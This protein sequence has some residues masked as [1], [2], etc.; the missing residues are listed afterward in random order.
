MLPKSKPK[1]TREE[2]EALIRDIDA[3]VIL[4]GVRG[5]YSKTFGD[6][7]N[8]LN[9][10]DDAIFL[11]SVNGHFSFNANTDPS[12]LRPRVAKLKQGLWH[13]RLGTHNISKPKSQQYPAL[14]QAAPVTVVR[15]NS[16]E[17]TGW[18]GINIH[19]GG[20]TTTS[21][22][23]CQTIPPNQWLGFYELV[24]TEMNRAKVSR[25]PYL[26]IDKA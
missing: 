16:G 26:L 22:L 8:D 12:I 7:G 2:T 1:Q 23:G 15:H 17:D 19:R 24:R 6:P 25:I 10:Y 13:Y 20:R 5:Y 18:F 9:V 21:S 3:P 4:L 14:I 11:W